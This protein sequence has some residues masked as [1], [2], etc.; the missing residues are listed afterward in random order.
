MPLNVTLDKSS[1]NLFQLVFPMV[2]HEQNIN[3]SNEL[4]LNVFSSIIPGISIS[5][6]SQDW[7]GMKT[8]F[9]TSELQFDP[10][11]IDFVV[12][13]KF[14]NWRM[15]FNWL[16]F[17]HNNSDKPM[18]I[19]KLY[20]IDASLI[21]LSAWR[22]PIINIKFYDIYPLSLGQVSLSMRDAQQLL[23]CNASFAF[24]RFN[25]ES[26]SSNVRLEDI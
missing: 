10:W 16:M 12:D 4:I 17:I 6:M 3:E 7:Q 23:E 25:I 18:E 21:I 9:A 2:P 1:P 13:K 24:Q 14:R 11:S 15:I 22:E 26:Y 5:E 8:T 20:K 19:S